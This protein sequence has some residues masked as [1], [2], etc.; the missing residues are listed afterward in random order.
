MQDKVGYLTTATLKEILHELDPKLTEEELIGIIGKAL[1]AC[2]HLWNSTCPI[3]TRTYHFMP[4]E[5]DGIIGKALPICA[6]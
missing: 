2:C 6:L 1:P 3:Y 5:L 4:T